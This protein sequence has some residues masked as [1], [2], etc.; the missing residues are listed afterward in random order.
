MSSSHRSGRGCRLRWDQWW[1]GA[2]ADLSANGVFNEPGSF[3][4]ATWLENKND[5]NEIITGKYEVT[6][7]PHIWFGYVCATPT[8]ALR[9]LCGRMR[10]PLVMTA[11]TASYD[12]GQARVSRSCVSAPLCAEV[13]GDLNGQANI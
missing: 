12:P 4:L 7:A 2:A 1:L 13:G 11:A 10:P 5:K 8:R 3:W 9:H 6:I